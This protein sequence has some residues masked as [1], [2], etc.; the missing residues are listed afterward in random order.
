M[1]RFPLRD[2]IPSRTRPLVTLAAAGAVG[3]LALW[4]APSFAMA[5]LVLAHVLP[6][7]VLG[8]T[9]EDQLGHD[10][11]AGVLV[12]AGVLG[13]LLPGHS[14]GVLPTLTAAVIGAH[15]AL[16]PTARILWHVLFDVLEVPSYFLIGCWVLLLVMTGGPV[17]AP[18][19]SL[20]LSAAAAR[21]LR[22]GDRARWS[23]FDRAA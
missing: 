13:Y 5:G 22:R 17:E 7:V 20:G 1:L 14:G 4:P 10:R 11:H 9:V 6:L 21:I 23:H 19:L 16:F 15:L 12:A 3:L 8:E 2:V 18:A